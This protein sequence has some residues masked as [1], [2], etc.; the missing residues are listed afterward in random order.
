MTRKST[1]PMPE[2]WGRAWVV[3]SALL[4]SA[5]ATVHSPKPTLSANG[6]VSNAASAGVAKKFQAAETAAAAT[7]PLPTAAESMLEAGLDSVYANCSDYFDSAGRAQRW[8]FVARDTV[9]SIGTLATS[10]IALRNGSE[11]AVANLALVTGVAFS[12]LDIYS[13]NFLFGAENVESVR[14][15]VTNALA[16]HRAAVMKAGPFTYGSATL[17]ILDN[18]NICTPANI[19]A[20]AREAIKKGTVVAFT[21]SPSDQPTISELADQKVL[22]S[23]GQL[24]NPPGTLSED[25]VGAFWWLLMSPQTLD[26]RKII[27]TKLKDLP[28]TSIPVD[29]AGTYN[30]TWPL[31]DNVRN[32]LNKL[33][34]DTKSSFIASV[35]DARKKIATAAAPGPVPGGVAAAALPPP[36]ISPFRAV[37]AT[38]KRTSHITIGIR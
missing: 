20:L 38:E 7:S 29:A 16:E 24:L 37:R 30:K 36:D 12:G 18:Q 28:S 2:I 14:T 32:E 27:Y 1:L 15:L 10:I 35:D 23:L 22:L 21:P 34:R 6:L 13:R 4:L 25:Q 5:C 19:L 26:D 3:L 33:S 17:H 11:N 9:G 31:A 8:V